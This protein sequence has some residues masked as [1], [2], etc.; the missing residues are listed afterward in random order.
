MGESSGKHRK[1]YVDRPSRESKICLIHGPGNSSDECKILGDFGAKFSKGNPTKYR[2]N[3]PVTSIF[4]TG[5]RKIIPLLIMWWM[6]S[7]YMKHKK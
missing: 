6:K 2:G 3:N 4:L 5:N 7:Y 1:K